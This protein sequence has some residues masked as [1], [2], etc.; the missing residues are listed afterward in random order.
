M[1]MRRQLTLAQARKAMLEGEFDGGVLGAAANVAVVLSQDWCGQW[2]EMDRWLGELA[3][4][5][6]PEHPEVVVFHLLYNREAF[7]EE[8]MRFKEDVL[9]NHLIPYVRYYRGGQL[10]GQSNYVSAPRFL[11]WFAAP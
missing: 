1:V 2:V 6:R 11:S 10:V 3:R 5:P 7:F 8:F 9:G 4:A